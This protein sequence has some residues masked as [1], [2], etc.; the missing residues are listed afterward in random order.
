MKFDRK[1]ASPLEAEDG[2][3]PVGAGRAG[4][5]QRSDPDRPEQH[6]DLQRGGSRE[7][8]RCDG[9]NGMDKPFPA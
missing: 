2:G 1:A 6:R 7:A 3:L 5:T 8:A 9:Q 4:L